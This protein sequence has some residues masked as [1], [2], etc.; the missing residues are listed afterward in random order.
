VFA[1]VNKIIDKHGEFSGI[2]T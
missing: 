2:V 1:H